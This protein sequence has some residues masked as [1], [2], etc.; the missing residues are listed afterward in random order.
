MDYNN[1]IFSSKEF[2]L[3][4][5]VGSTILIILAFLFY[6]SFLAAIFISPIFSIYLSYRKHQKQKYR[7]QKLDVQFKDGIVSLSAALNAGYSVENSFLEALRDLNL[8]YEKEAFIIKEF[9]MIIYKLKMNQTVED[10]LWD[11]AKRSGLQNIENFAEVFSTAKRTGGDLIK[12]IECTSKSINEKIEVSREISTLIAGKQYE[13]RVMSIVPLGII[14]YM[15]LFSPGFMQPL[16][17]NI[18]GNIIMTIALCSYL[19]ALKLM[20]HIIEIEL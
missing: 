11:F 2:L 13:S 8:L 1:Y 6:E 17:H 10:A 7:K 4:L 5:I 3:E 20:Q 12:I 16:Y 15:Q 18:M 19:A 9:E 14:L